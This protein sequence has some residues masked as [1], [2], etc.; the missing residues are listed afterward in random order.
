[1]QPVPVRRP[2]I[3]PVLLLLLAAWLAPGP[4]AAQQVTAPC[5]EE[6]APFDGVTWPITLLSARCKTGKMVDGG[7][8]IVVILTVA[9]GSDEDDK[10]TIDIDLLDDA[11]EVVARANRRQ[12][13]EVEE[14]VRFDIKLVVDP[15]RIPEITQIRAVASVD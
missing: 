11:G 7:Q 8:R 14:A 10:V 12:G 6:F 3:A 5:G 9:N 13:V 1:M 15:E 2:V 4:L